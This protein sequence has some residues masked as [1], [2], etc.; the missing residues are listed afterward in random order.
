MFHVAY[1]ASFALPAITRVA[2]AAER[3][4]AFFLPG[5]VSLRPLLRQY[6]PDIRPCTL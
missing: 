1:V 6:V 5:S 3:V 4:F 2:F